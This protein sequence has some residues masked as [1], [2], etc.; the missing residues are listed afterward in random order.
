[1]FGYAKWP[2]TP[3]LIL[4]YLT[5]KRKHHGQ[6]YMDGFSKLV[7]Y[8]KH[9]TTMVRYKQAYITALLSVGGLNIVLRSH[10]FP[11]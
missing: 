1:M 11:A 8:R 5:F 3:C 7:V 4:I 6:I 10:V 2:K 9:K